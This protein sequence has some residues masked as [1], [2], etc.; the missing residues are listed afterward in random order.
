MIKYGQ[1]HELMAVY[2]GDRLIGHIQNLSKF[3]AG[4][5]FVFLPRGEAQGATIYTTLEECQEALNV[6]EPELRAGL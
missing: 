6:A 4:E 3:D 2:I 1:I 5:G